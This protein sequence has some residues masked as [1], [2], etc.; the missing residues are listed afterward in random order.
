MWSVRGECLALNARIAGGPLQAL[1]AGTITGVFYDAFQEEPDNP[2]LLAS[3]KDGIPVRVLHQDTPFEIRIWL[4]DWHN[5]FHTGSGYS[6]LDCIS[7]ILNVILPKWTIHWD[8]LGLSTREKIDGMSF[9]QYYWCWIKKHYPGYF[10]GWH[11]YDDGRKFV[12]FL[13]KVMG[14]NGW[15][16]YKQTLSRHIDFAKATG[17]QSDLIVSALNEIRLLLDNSIF[18]QSM[19]RW[20]QQIILIELSKYAFPL[21]Q[22]V[23][24]TADQH[25]DIK[26]LFTDGPKTKKILE[27]CFEAMA[28][29]TST[30]VIKMAAAKSH[31]KQA[32][33]PKVKSTGAGS[34]SQQVKVKKID[35]KTVGSGRIEHGNDFVE[36]AGDVR[37]RVWLD[38]LQQA[39]VFALGEQDHSQ[40]LP[41]ALQP[42]V[43]H[44]MRIAFAYAFNEAVTIA[45]TEYTK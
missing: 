13:L 27:V 11:M 9:A 40:P 14:E 16:I 28:G 43:S 21:V 32:P 37:A 31:K 18:S 26:W 17:A 20:L 39:I 36:S 41:N 4:R 44:A 3:L 33:K 35:L 34:K 30:K 25:S 12:L 42:V 29:S 23:D 22:A 38:D 24:G 45:S 1:A 6:V 15:D 7:D 10:N 19:P 8:S 2:N 5:K